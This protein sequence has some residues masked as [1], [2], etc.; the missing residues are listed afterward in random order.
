MKNVL[1]DL[2]GTIA[3]H[4]S[5]NIDT[6]GDPIPNMID[7]LKNYIMQ[8]YDVRIFTARVS[9]PEQESEQRSLIEAWCLKNIG[10]V[11]LVQNFKDI[12]TI[13]I[14]DDRAYHVHKNI[15]TY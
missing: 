14:Y 11:L 4:E 8:G 9:I 7:L 13:A 15:G 1:F 12:N 3:I 6:I 2:D 5:G 10:V